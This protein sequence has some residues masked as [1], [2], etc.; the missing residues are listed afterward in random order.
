[1]I[2]E[3][4]LGIVFLFLLWRTF[5]RKPPGLPPGRWGLPLIGYIPLTMKTVEE[6]LHDMHKQYGDIFLWRMGTQVM[7]FLNDYKLTRAAFS[8]TDFINRPDWTLFN[9]FEEK[10]L[11]QQFDLT[12]PKLIEFERIMKDLFASMVPFSVP[13]FLP[14]I[15][16]I[17][18]KYFLN[19][20]FQ[21]GFLEDAK[22]RILQFFFS[23]IEEHRATLDRDNPRD[24]IDGYLIEMDEKQVDPDVTCNDTDLSILILDL[25]LGGGESTKGILVWMS[26]YLATYPE[27]QRRM[28]EEVDEVL[29]KGTLATL[30]DRIRLPY[31]EA[32]LH[33]VLRK[34]SLVNL[35]VQHVAVRDTELGGY[36]I[37]KGLI[38][39][40]AAETMHHNPHYWDRPDEFLPERWL[41]H[42]GKFTNS[43]KEGFLP[44]GVGKRSCLGESLARME[45]LIFSTALMQ[46][47]SFSHP[48]GKK[49][50][51]RPEPNNPFFRNPQMQDIVITVR[52]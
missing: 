25:F 48:P 36:I 6:Q 41:D 7:V 10:A 49:I 22:E 43:K 4:V 14:W 19:H 46:S 27:V 26:Y 29:P 40:S 37:P 8:S 50:H 44:F 24:L 23:E 9:F 31:T 34:S 12:D 47:L 20:V 39:S 3:L 51:L 21:Y 33:E 35:G 15:T 5:F 18:P 28:Q 45:L 32:V 16:Y 30:E 38:I 1:M 2:A 13:D 11:G 17:L 52:H 42:E